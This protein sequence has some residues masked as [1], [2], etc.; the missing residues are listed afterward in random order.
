MKI[1]VMALL[2]VFSLFVSAAF[3]ACGEVSENEDSGG[4][5]KPGD[6]GSQLSE[7]SKDESLPPPEPSEYTAL[8]RRFNDTVTIFGKKD[9]LHVYSR[10]QWEYDEETVGDAIND[11]VN[12]RNQW[13]F[14]HYGIQI[15]YIASGH[16]DYFI[17][18]AVENMILSGGDDYD[19]V[20]DGLTTMAIL[21]GGGYLYSLNG[22]S[23]YLDRAIPGGTKGSATPFL[24]IMKS[25]MPPGIF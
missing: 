6:E 13:L 3:A 23:E 4:S 8:D 7:T 5:K 1:R 20:C 25:I 21:A 12:D 10:L 17:N 11:A 16:E 22:L 14:D 2:I 24:S 9:G 18:A 19:V 15:K